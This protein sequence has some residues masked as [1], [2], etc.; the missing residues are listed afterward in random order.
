M[1]RLTSQTFKSVL[2]SKS[3]FL[4]FLSQA[5]RAHISP[6]FLDI[7]QTFRFA[8]ALAGVTP[9][10]GVF[11]VNRPDGVLLIVVENNLVDGIVLLFLIIHFDLLFFS[12]E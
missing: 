8:A 7:R 2:V 10:Q 3:S 6:D 9:T 12:S 11:A 4:H 1:Q 5:E